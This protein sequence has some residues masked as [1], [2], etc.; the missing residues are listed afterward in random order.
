ML[1]LALSRTVGAS[2]RVPVAVVLIGGMTTSTLLTLVVVPA[3]YTYFDDFRRWLVRLRRFGHKAT[4]ES[5]A[6]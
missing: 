6:D 5:M 1:P 3:L 2:D 4:T